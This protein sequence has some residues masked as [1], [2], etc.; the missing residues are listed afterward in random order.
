VTERR[1]LKERATV[2]FDGKNSVDR[3]RASNASKSQSV[4]IAGEN[5]SA[6]STNFSSSLRSL[7]DII[8]ALP[9]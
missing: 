8:Q 3:F 2:V 4:G 1:T 6:S 9:K 5:E 7:A